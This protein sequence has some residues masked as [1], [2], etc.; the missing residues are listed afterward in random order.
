[1]RIG[2]VAQEWLNESLPI[3]GS[4]PVPLIHALSVTRGEWRSERLVLHPLLLIWFRN[5]DLQNTLG[6]WPRAGGRK[7]ISTSKTFLRFLSPF[8][9]Q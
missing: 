7:F 3:R 5:P 4:F 8:R 9:F 6:I 1:M 2:Y